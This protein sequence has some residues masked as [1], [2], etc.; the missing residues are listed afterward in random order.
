MMAWMGAKNLA[1]QRYTELTE[2]EE[3]L[4]AE[5]TWQ[6]FDYCL[7]LAAFGS[8]EELKE[9]VADPK[10]WIEER[11]RVAVVTSDQIPFWVGLGHRKTVYAAFEREATNKHRR[12]KSRD[13]LETPGGVQTSQTAEGQVPAE[14]DKDHAEGQTQKRGLNAGKQKLRITFENRNAILHQIALIFL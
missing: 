5:L 11:R 1:P 4:R 8:E 2:E 12:R 13:Y 3:A 9:V 6:L 7:Q 10:K 14:M